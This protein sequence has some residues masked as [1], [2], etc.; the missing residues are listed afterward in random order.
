MVAK[1]TS[2]KQHYGFISMSLLLLLCLGGCGKQQVAQQ[3]ISLEPEEEQ[4]LFETVTVDYGDVILSQ[5]IQCTYRQVEDQEVC[6]T[7]SGRIIDRIYV[8]V[9]DMVH[10]GDLLAELETGD[11]EEQI[12][13]TEYQVQRNKLLLDQ[14]ERN[15][16]NETDQL[17]VQYTYHTEQTS[18]DWTRK[19]KSLKEIEEQHRYLREDYS[20]AIALGEAQLAVWQKQQD[21]SRVYAQ[22]DGVISSIERDLEGSVCV[23]DE[24]VMTLIDTSECLFE[25]QKEEYVSFFKENEPVSMTVSIGTGKGDYLL[26]PYDMEHWG[27]TQTFSIEEQPEGAVLEVGATGTI[28]LIMD[29]RENVLRIPSAAVHNADGKDYVYVTDDTGMRK[30]TY[31]EAGLKGNDYTEILSGITEGERVILKGWA[32]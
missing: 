25:T 18:E 30:V 13:Q 19:E 4:A 6:F 9:G 28:F 27:E 32:K 10:K 1:S 16:K 15:L 12:A 22:I 20:D 5:K 11:L 17:M 26:L 29:Q 31:V 24:P 8:S 2:A 14:N 3:Q 7:V 23:K 21:E